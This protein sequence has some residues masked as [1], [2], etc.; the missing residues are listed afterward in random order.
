MRRRLVRRSAATRHGRRALLALPAAAALLTL[1]AGAALPGAASAAEPAPWPARPLRLVVPFPAGG[2]V[3][4][5]ARALAQRLGERLAQTVLV[6]NRAGAGGNIGLDAVA[7]AAPDGHVW[8]ITASSVA[9]NPA[10]MKSYVDPLRDVVPVAQLSRYHLVYYVR[11]GLAVN[12]GAEL[13]AL[14]RSRPGEIS[15]GAGGGGT[16]LAC[17][18]LQQLAGAKMIVPMYKGST[19]ALAALATGQIDVAV[20]L[21]GAGAGLVASG[22]VKPVARADSRPALPG[23]REAGLLAIPGVELEGWHGVF[24]PP[25]TPAA[26]VERFHRELAQLMR[27]PGMMARLREL[28]LDPAFGSAEQFVQMLREDIERHRRIARDAGLQPE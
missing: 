9:V 3:D 16:R 24:A 6:E 25:G 13:I 20:D 21:A 5:L 14:V 11:Q 4:L 22:L 26:L 17:E 23:S 1:A 7:H 10:L 18:L 27:E 12:N 19:A 2:T 8:G 15:C 28:D